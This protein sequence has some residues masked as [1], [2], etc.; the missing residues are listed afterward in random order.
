MRFSVVVIGALAGAFTATAACS[1]QTVT[2]SFQVKITI[3]TSCTVSATNLDFGSNGVLAANVDQTSTVTVTCSA[4]TPYNVGLSAG[5][6]SGA[7]VTTRQMQN[8]ASTI[9]Y[10]LFRDSGRTQNWGNTVG[11]D[12]VSGT[13]SGIGQNISVYGRVPPQ[14]TP[15]PGAYTDTITVTVT[16]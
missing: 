6:A 12:T 7:T 9:N 8:G 4:T 2:T 10:S 1:A 11:T 15:A 3:Q 14:A 16:Y 13:G 5:T